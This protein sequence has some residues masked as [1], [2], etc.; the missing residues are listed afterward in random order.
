MT[1]LDIALGNSYKEVNWKMKSV[2]W[3]EFVARLRKVRRTSET[4]AQYDAMTKDQRDEV[5]DGSCFVAGFLQGGRRKK[6]ALESRSMITLDADAADENF[7]DTVDLAL[8]GTSYVIYSTHSHRDT[9]HRYRVIIQPNRSMTPDEYSAVSRKLAEIIGMDYF[10]GTTFQVERLMYFPSCSVDAEP[11]LIEAVGAP[12]DVDGVLA[13]YI[14]WTDIGAWPRHPKEKGAVQLAGARAEDPREKPGVIGAF[15]R[16]YSI[17]EG[18]DTFLGDV[19]ESG[20]MENRYTYLG[21]HSG[22]G[23]EIYP[24]QDL[25]Y[26]H[27]DS[28]PG[29][30]GRTHNLFDLVRLHLF[31]EKDEDVKEGTNLVK[32]PS[33]EAMLAFAVADDRVKGELAAVEAARISEF[34]VIEDDEPDAPA[35]G[36]ADELSWMKKLERN[37]DGKILPSNLNVQLMLTNKPFKGVLAFDAFKNAEVIKG[38]LP[39]RTMERKNAMYE[40]W[41]GPDDIEL[42]HYLGLVYKVKGS[43]TIKEAFTNAVRRNKFHPI[44]EYLEALQWD[45]VK[46][47]DSLFI[48]YMGAEDNLYTRTV[49]RKIFVAA[50]KRLYEPGCKFDE[51]LVLVGP[52]ATGKSTILKRMGRQWFSDSLKTFEGKEAGEHLQNSWIFEFAE[53]AG[54][55]KAEVEEVKAF[56][57]R[58]TDMY[59]VAYDRVVSEFPRKCVFFGT[60]NNFNFLKDDTGNRR[61]WPVTANV[62]RIK[63]SSMSEDNLK[64]DEVGQLWAEAK[65]LYDSGEPVTLSKDVAMMAERIQSMHMEGDPR[66]GLIMEYLDSPETEEF[67]GDGAPRNIVCAAEIWVNCLNKNKGDMKPWD[68]KAICDIIRRLP[69]WSEGK[70]TRFKTFGIQTSFVR[71][72]DVAVSVAVEK[73]LQQ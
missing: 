35:E 42:R 1:D 22:N 49:T 6:E 57:S 28:D 14:N 20:T 47:L 60:T 27:Q 61:F 40:P 63:K 53:L 64:D 46:R 16:A 44:K 58:S 59:R 68:A 48:D 37:K 34:D 17:E 7:I 30:N 65:H 67:A 52:Q 3:S 33:H 73:L 24:D 9:A 13:E 15:C 43:E 69:G 50:V 8:G 23:L 39:W 5:K 71:S 70:R 41:A 38:P 11:V 12:L 31:A 54:M 26:S 4:L 2:T 32:L 21:G 19:Y 56:T 62:S 25:A 18:I 66:E 10:D 36:D 72:G 29:A 51:M 45:G 55:K